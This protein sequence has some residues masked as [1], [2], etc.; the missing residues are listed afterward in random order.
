MTSFDFT[1][2]NINNL[3]G[4]SDAENEQETRLKEYFYKNKAYANLKNELSIRILVGHKGSGKSA[5]LKMLYIEDKDRNFPAI[6]LQPGDL[7]DTFD[8]KK[9]TFNSWIESWKHTLNSVIVNEV[10]HQVMPERV[11]ENF[12]SIPNTTQAIFNYIRNKL[13]KIDKGISEKISEDAIKIF[14][15]SEFIRVYIDDLDRGWSGNANDIKKIST[16]FNAI[17]DLCGSQNRI[18]FRIGLRTNIY[19]LVRTS[20]ESTDKIEDKIVW[21]TWSNN[22]ILNLFAKRI[23]TFF[24]A[25]F[26]EADFNRKSQQEVSMIFNQVLDPTFSGKGKWSNVRM[27][28]V[29]MSL[30]R[31]RPR[32]LVK[33]LGSAAKE[34]YKNNHTRIKTEDLQNI[35]NSYSSERLQDI[36]N[37]FSSELPTIQRLLLAMKPERRAARA[38]DLYTFSQAELDKK[39][40][41][42]MTSNNFIFSNKKPVTTRSIGQFLYKID[43]V[44]ARK[45]LENGAIDR[46]YHDQAKFLF[47]Q[48]LDFGYSWEIHPA[49][50]WALQPDSIEKIFQQTDLEKLEIDP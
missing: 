29:L 19:H 34:A 15:Q 23:Q 24:G 8:Q 21:L 26:D 25:N 11:K 17:R 36:I 37:E 10:M 43:F 18:Q 7:L 38:S 42:I 44:I 39:I 1:D 12:E 4:V 33:L 22:D 49:Y 6:W 48:N 31:K 30:Q 32:D 13:A 50:R 45:T 9:E 14:S 40:A 16:L 2:E 20:D 41:N 47:D 28:R 46:K 35:F 27:H 3:F 5:L